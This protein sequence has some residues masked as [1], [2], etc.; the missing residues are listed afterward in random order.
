MVVQCFV[1]TGDVL[2]LL[3]DRPD[4]VA[5]KDDGAVAVDLG[6]Q[7]V[8]AGFEALVDIGAR[9]VENEQ[10]RVADDGASQQGALQLSADQLPES[11]VF[12]SLESHAEDDLAGFLTLRGVEAADQRFL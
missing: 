1:H 10:L 9:F 12:Q 5:D 8:E 6:Q 4:V 2:H 3:Q 11:T 7:L